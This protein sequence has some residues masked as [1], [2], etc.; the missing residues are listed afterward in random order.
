MKRDS[1]LMEKKRA[2]IVDGPNTGLQMVP[3]HTHKE[4]NRERQPPL[5]TE[6][7]KLKLKQEKPL[8]NRTHSILKHNPENY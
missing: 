3:T 1:N 5:E 7:R 6:P 8:E 4:S 2:R